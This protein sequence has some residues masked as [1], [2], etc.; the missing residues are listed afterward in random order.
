[1]SENHRLELSSSIDDRERDRWQEDNILLLAAKAFK[2]VLTSVLLAAVGVDIYP[3]EHPLGE[4][5]PLG[6]SNR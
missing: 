3:R 4:I 2:A 6:A 1:M 5:N